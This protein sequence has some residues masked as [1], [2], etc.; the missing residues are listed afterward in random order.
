MIPKPHSDDL[1]GRFREVI[2]DPLNLL[3]RR[4][5]EAGMI[6]DGKVILHNGHRVALDGPEAYYDDFSRLFVLNRGVHEPLE[7]F[8]FQTVL[9]WMPE[10][11]VMIE[12]GAYW[13]HY[14]MWMA[15]ARPGA[16]LYL[17]EPE[18]ENLAAG[19]ANFAANGYR[20]TF[21]QEMVGKTAFGVDRFLAE[22]GL[23]HIDLL[24]ADI[25][26]AEGEMVED[27]ARA[28]AAQ[29]IDW[30]FIST[31]NRPVHQRCET[32]LQ[33]AGYRV[34]V[35]SDFVTHTTSHD[36]FLMAGSPKTTPLFTGL[37]APLGRAE[38]SAPEPAALLASLTA[39]LPLVPDL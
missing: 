3:I 18:A 36:G 7:E 8:C 22:T 39:F 37:P 12:L 23:T 21:R 1:E 35:S 17:V 6:V 5:P 24:H 28:L 26:G 34:E 32:L 16:D 25:Q 33:A 20:G 14:S 13:A 38:L 15:Q 30:L 19:R 11:P 9:P 29:A 2:A 27:A 31:H 10:R 4:H